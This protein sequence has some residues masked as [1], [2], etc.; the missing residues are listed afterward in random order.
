MLLLVT[1]TVYAEPLDAAGMEKIMSSHTPAFIRFDPEGCGGTCASLDSFWATLGVE[2][3]GMVNT[4]DCAAHP[5]VCAARKV[6]FDP[7]TPQG[8][9]P[10]FKFWTGE[11]FRRYTSAPTPTML[12][13]YLYKKL[14]LELPADKPMAREARAPTPT[15]TPPARAG[16]PPPPRASWGKPDAQTVIATIIFLTIDC[17]LL[18]LYLRR[19]P[20]EAPATMLVVGTY[21]EKL[22]HVD[23]KG[24][25]FY[26]FRIDADAAELAPL[27]GVNLGLPS[28]SY[29]CADGGARAPG[30]GWLLHASSEQANGCV[31]SLA[32]DAGAS[33][34]L[35]TLGV[36]DAKGSWTCH[37]AV[38]PGGLL[39]AANYGDD[40]IALLE[41]TL[42]KRGKPTGARTRVEVLRTKGTPLP[43]GNPQR[44]EGPHAHIALPFTPPAA[45]GKAGG[46]AH[47]LVC[48][49]GADLLLQYEV[50]DGGDGS[51]VRLVGSVRLPAGAGPRHAAMH[52]SQQ[53]AYVL[54]ELD[55]NLVVVSLR[56][57]APPSI[58]T[59][60]S[61]LPSG[62]EG[63]GAKGKKK[64]A[65][66]AAAKG[67]HPVN[68]SAVRCSADG[69]FV[70]AAVRGLD[71]VTTLR[72]DGGG[73][74][75]VAVAHTFTG[76]EGSLRNTP[77]DIVLTGGADESLLLVAN[78]D[79]NTIGVFTRDGETGVPKLSKTVDCP[80]PCC[81]LPIAWPP[82]PL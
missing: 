75:A 7:A 61:V 31:A 15:P 11:S 67:G 63:G 79:T 78:Q 48:D 40:S 47:L 70:Y 42:D 81:L 77:R 57:D 56:R 2:F 13:A 39:A 58:V 38:A 65:A 37:V 66:P 8:T 5:Q 22:G 20:T 51:R 35:R 4:V 32:F 25:G 21:T 10:I 33:P 71:I 62:G 60:T 44:Q 52:P 14:G 3:P 49:L 69:R 82:P 80:S 76:E 74:K 19:P 43:G 29:L 24:D 46:A 16:G 55:N 50:T 53:Y 73:K 17:Y 6:T 26:V 36:E 64:A 1:S 41:R 23:G 59:S 9:V 34:C 68:A 18:F 54:C 27:S 30:G 45:D 28:P 72:L 12:R